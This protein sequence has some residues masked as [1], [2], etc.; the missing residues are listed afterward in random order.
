MV[1]QVPTQ[2]PKGTGTDESAFVAPLGDLEAGAIAWWGQKGFQKTAALELGPIDIE[3]IDDCVPNRTSCGGDNRDAAY[4]SDYTKAWTLP[5]DASAFLLVLGVDSNAT[6]KATYGNVNV[7]ACP[8]DGGV[9]NISCNGLA[10]VDSR[11]FPGTAAPFAAT[12]DALYA[13]HASRDCDAL[14]ATAG[15]QLL[16]IQVD[17]EGVLHCDSLRVVARAY[18]EV[19]TT[20]G[21]SYDELARPRVLEF[22][23]DGTLS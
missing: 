12:G 21:P 11:S 7:E 6:G 2:L 19:A 14:E 1:S 18:V 5:A 23:A 16:C 17:C 10:G 9:F 20:T 13:V 3:G 8:R 15:R 4:L 22:R